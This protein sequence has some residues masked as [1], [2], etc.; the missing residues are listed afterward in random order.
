MASTPR[1][2]PRPTQGN[3]RLLG[4]IVA[5]VA[6][7][8]IAAAWGW[9]RLAAAPATE[10][11]RPAWLGVNRVIAQLNDGRLLKVR[12]D[13]R[14]TDQDAVSALTP[15]QD[16]FKALVEEVGGDMSRAE[17]EGAE[18]MQTMAQEIRHTLNSYL[19]S[20]RMPQRVRAV[21]F[22]EW[23]LLPS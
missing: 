23:T 16:A 7:L 10:R 5:G 6:V 18:G 1:P 14:L 22:G 19:A 15:H 2:P 13:L 11:P 21:M 3:D 8:A 9:A 17:L 12:V 20:Q 4:L